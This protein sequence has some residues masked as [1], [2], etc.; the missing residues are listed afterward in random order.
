VAEDTIVIGGL[1]LVWSHPWI[2]LT[3]VVGTGLSVA[4]IVWWLWRKLFR[5]VSRLL[6]SGSNTSG[7]GATA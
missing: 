6:S 3:I 1:A 5:G 4:L 7:P 2:A